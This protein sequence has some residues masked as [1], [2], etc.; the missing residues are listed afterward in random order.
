MHTLISNELLKLRTSRAPWILLAA[1]LLLVLAA[2]S[3]IVISGED[4]RNAATTR[5]M[6]AHAGPSFIF[7]LVLGITA[8]AGEYRDGTIADTFLA[9][10]RRSRIILAKLIAYGGAGLVFGLLST[11]TALGVTVVSH[12]VAGAPLDL[13]TTD[14]WTTMAGTVAFMA[15]TCIIGVAIGAIFTNI[16]ASIGVALAWTALIE[17]TM[18]SLLGDLGRWLPVLSGF[19]LQN[20]PQPKMLPQLT[21]GLVFA[22]YALV[23]AVAA[24]TVTTR[25]DVS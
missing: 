3:G 22:A 19:A 4:L 23:F 8:V 2:V 7:V 25:R 1:Q 6:L 15:L 12:A 9:T 17:T 20:V 21:G 13:A 24:L 14:V 18:Y 5:L 11:L 16:G 10:P